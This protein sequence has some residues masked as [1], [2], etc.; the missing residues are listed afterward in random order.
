MLEVM[1]LESNIKRLCLPPT[2]M[3]CINC[4]AENLEAA[5]YCRKCGAAMGEDETRVAVKRADPRHLAAKDAPPDDEARIFSISPTLKFVKAGYALAAV[6]ALLLVV[7]L[8]MFTP[9]PPWAAVLAGLLLFLMPAFYHFKQKM[10]RYTLT[11]TKLEID[12]GFIARRTR[13]VPLRRIQ[14]VTVQAS[15]SQRMLGFGDLMIDNASD[16]GGKVVLKNI[17]TP[18]EYADMVLKQMRRL[19]R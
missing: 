9:V 7:I 19:E 14:D 1:A 18:R 6:G 13:N 3:Y 16:E 8:A 4:G 10:M 11:D 12:E 15:V 17:D 5:S 2:V